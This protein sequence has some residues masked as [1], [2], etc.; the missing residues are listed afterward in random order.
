M[1]RSL[2][3]ANATYDNMA[4]AWNLVLDAVATA[5]PP[6]PGKATGPSAGAAAT[7]RPVCAEEQARLGDELT[8]VQQALIGRRHRLCPEVLALHR[9]EQELARALRRR[10]H[11]TESA[12][13]PAG[14]DGAD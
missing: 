2:A 3:G 9:R 12:P 14:A 1:H 11:C 5:K 7:T 13:S 4:E 10:A 6:P 8:A